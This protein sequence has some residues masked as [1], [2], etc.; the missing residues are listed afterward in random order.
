M[1]KLTYIT[2]LLIS[3][4]TTVYTSYYTFTQYNND[5]IIATA[6]ITATTTAPAIETLDPNTLKTSTGKKITVQNTHPVGESVSTITITTN[7]FIDNTPVILKKNK[8]TN[9]FLADL[10]KDGFDELILTTLSAGSGSYGDVLI[11]TTAGDQALAR[12]TTPEVK[13]EDTKKGGL[14][15]GYLG[16]D[17]F[18][19]L[20]GA[21][22]REFPVYG[23]GDTNA[24]SSLPT[25]KLIYSLVEEDGTY[26]AVLFDASSTKST[27]PSLTSTSTS[28]STT[29][30]KQDLKYSTSTHATSTQKK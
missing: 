15:E 6:V 3:L 13:E 8:L 26:V 16:H 12:I 29:P 27:L 24:S 18:N 1:K 5:Q 2:L 23:K 17:S 4:G 14:F 9:F 20:D 21:L 28:A 7:G 22:I 19:L 10:N 25:K 30:L 11:F